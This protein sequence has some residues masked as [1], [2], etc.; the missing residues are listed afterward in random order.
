MQA[1]QHQIVGTHFGEE[2][3]KIKLPI[4]S[5]VIGQGYLHSGVPRFKFARLAYSAALIIRVIHYAGLH[6][7][8]VL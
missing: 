8:L 7:H 5:T 2:A 3:F 6:P 1:A 4:K